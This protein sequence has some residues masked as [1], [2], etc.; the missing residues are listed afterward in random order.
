MCESAREREREATEVQ[1]CIRR[2]MKAWSVHDRLK[3]LCHAISVVVFVTPS[4]STAKPV[5]LH[6]LCSFCIVLFHSL[7]MQMT[8]LNL[9]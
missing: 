7:N 8:G 5:F 3:C 4:L 9:H 6:I 2:A 1:A